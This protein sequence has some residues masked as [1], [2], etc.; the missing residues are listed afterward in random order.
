MGNLLKLESRALG[1]VLLCAAVGAGA[2]TLGRVRGTALI[3]QPLDLSIQVQFDGEENASSLCMEADVFH[4]DTRQDP[5]R[6]KVSV[7]TTQQPQMATV[8]AESSCACG[9]AHGDSLS[10]GWLWSKDHPPVRSSRRLPF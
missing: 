3:G 10:E 5:A 6:V 2:M 9:R 4:A 1:A 7:G 8:R